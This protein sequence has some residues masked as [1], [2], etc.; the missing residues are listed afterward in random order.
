VVG[1]VETGADE[2]DELKFGDRLH[3]HQSRAASRAFDRAFRDRRVDDRSLPNSS[4][5]PSVTLKAPPY[6]PTF[7]D[8]ENIRVGFH[9]FPDA[10]RDG[11]DHRGRTATGGTFDL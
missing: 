3:A 4:I 9:L 7:A 5:N 1:Q 2:I 10:R 8:N 6:A 11:L